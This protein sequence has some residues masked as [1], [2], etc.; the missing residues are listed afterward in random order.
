MKPMLGRPEAPR[1]AVLVRRQQ[2]GIGDVSRTGCR[3]EGT[4]PLE[5]GAVG[6]LA[7]EIGGRPHVEWFRVCRSGPLSGVAGR[8]EAGVEFLPMPA[9]TA[10]LH[11]VAAHFDQSH[12]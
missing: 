9:R 5:L 1:R 4:E 3:L 6:M 10:S 2:V 12:L 8:Y 11:D 7:A